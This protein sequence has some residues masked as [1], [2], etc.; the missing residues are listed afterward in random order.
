MYIWIVEC[1]SRHDL[2]CVVGVRSSESRVVV[3]DE[4][5]RSSELVHLAYVCD[6]SDVRNSAVEAVV[7]T[8]VSRSVNEC[9]SADSVKVVDNEH[10]PF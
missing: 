8:C 2:A 5:R 6:I 1:I 3:C 4:L 7:E 9:R 10:F